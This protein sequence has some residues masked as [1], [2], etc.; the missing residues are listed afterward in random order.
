VHIVRGASLVGLLALAA[1]SAAAALG[2]GRAAPAPHARYS[3]TGGDYYN[4]G[5]KDWVRA[6]TE[7]FSFEISSNG[8]DVV[9]FRGPYSYY[10]GA[11]TATLTAHG[12]IHADGRFA[13][14]FSKRGPY[15][16]TYGEASG[17][18]AAGGKQ[19]RVS[20]IVDFVESGAHVSDPYDTKDPH[21]LGCASWVRGTATTGALAFPREEHR[22]DRFE[23]V[24]GH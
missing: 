9:D 19:A 20:Y 11:G 6:G 24:G 1:S 3:G 22:A 13:I 12:P 4:N 2:A 5:A 16:T 7:R 10:C 14:R 17:I 15:G 8:R 18:F 21:A 23:L